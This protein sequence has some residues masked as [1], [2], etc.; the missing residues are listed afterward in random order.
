MH[1]RKEGAKKKKKLKKQNILLETG[2][3]QCVAPFVRNWLKQKNFSGEIN[4][5]PFLLMGGWG[6]GAYFGKKKNQENPSNIDIRN[7]DGSS[8][9]SK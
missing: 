5:F 6:W 1:K 3:L 7:S 9:N 8:L 4:I 2:D